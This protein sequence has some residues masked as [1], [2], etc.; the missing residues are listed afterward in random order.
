MSGISGGG[1]TITPQLQDHYRDLVISAETNRAFELNRLKYY[2]GYAPGP[3]PQIVGGMPS[4]YERKLVESGLSIMSSN[5]LGTSQPATALVELINAERLAESINV[6][7]DNRRNVVTPSDNVFDTMELTKCYRHGGQATVA[8][9]YSI[10]SPG[11]YQMEAN[12]YMAE[13]SEELR[14]QGQTSPLGIEIRQD[15]SNGELI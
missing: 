12:F 14:S 6:M 9:P 7:G 5:N 4:D 11:R 8:S 2:S 1:V 3:V 15:G 13:S 10:I